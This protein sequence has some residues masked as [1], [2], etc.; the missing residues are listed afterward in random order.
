MG[1]LEGDVAK[2]GSSL[3]FPFRL[4]FGRRIGDEPRPFALSFALVVVVVLDRS[5][6]FA[7]ALVGVVVVVVIVVVVIGV[8][9]LVV[10]A[11]WFAT[12]RSPPQAEG[13]QH[14][15]NVLFELRRLQVTFHRLGHLGL[16]LYKNVPV[17]VGVCL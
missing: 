11:I 9:A 2:E 17:L 13:F 1:I 6:A 3:S 10:G 16:V 8:A 12:L 7:T 4:A 14:L 5:E 15:L